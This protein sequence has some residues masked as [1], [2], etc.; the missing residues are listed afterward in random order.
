MYGVAMKMNSVM[1]RPTLLRIAFSFALALCVPCAYAADGSCP[2]VFDALT[3]V[4]MTPHHTFTTETF[5]SRGG[6]KPRI[7]ESILTGGVSYLQVNGKWMRSSY[8]PQEM[9][10]QSDENRKNVRVAA[11]RL[12]RDEVVSG[13]ATSVYSSHTEN[14]DAKTDAQVWI[15]KSSGLPLREEIDMDTGDPAKRHISMRYEYTN[16]KAPI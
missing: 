12:L 3:K 8:T 4:I 7:S 6:D 2:L 1:T 9:L 10:K 15:S 5:A 14:E 16:V 13:E 11:C